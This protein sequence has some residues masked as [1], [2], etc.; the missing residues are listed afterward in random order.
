MGDGVY[1]VCCVSPFLLLSCVCPIDLTER[2]DPTQSHLTVTVTVTVPLP[3]THPSPNTT[4]TGKDT[5]TRAERGK[6][7]R[8]ERRGEA[9]AVSRACLRVC[10]L[11][12]L[13][14]TEL[15]FVLPVA[16]RWSV[17]GGRCA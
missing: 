12:R 2:F 16:G 17:V 4:T 5:H 9:V 3:V 15:H 13:R 8:G 11:S 1:R 6:E 10:V 7:R 14:S